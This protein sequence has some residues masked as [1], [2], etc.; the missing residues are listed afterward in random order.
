M[1]LLQWYE[2]MQKFMLVK[3]KPLSLSDSQLIKVKMGSPME[4][5]NHSICAG[6]PLPQ[7][8]FIPSGNVPVHLDWLVSKDFLK[9]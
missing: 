7:W 4:R 1:V 6:L 8:I 3:V 9:F 5:L 2:P